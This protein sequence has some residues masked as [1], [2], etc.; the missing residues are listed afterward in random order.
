MDDR[1]NA[2]ET[3]MIS[4][5]IKSWCQTNENIVFD[6]SFSSLLSKTLFSTQVLDSIFGVNKNCG[7]WKCGRF[8]MY[9]IE[10]NE[11][12]IDVY[13]VAQCRGLNKEQVPLYNVLVNSFN[14]V[15]ELE[16]YLKLKC[17]FN[18]ERNSGFDDIKKILSLGFENKLLP[19]EMNLVSKTD[20]IKK[21]LHEGAEKEIL[22]NTYER[23]PEARKKCLE[24]HGYYCHI[25]GFDP[26]KI[27]GEEFKNKI[28]V[29]H[30]VPLSQIKSD[31]VVDPINDLI[32]VCPNCHTIL[33]SKP[34]GVYTP[35]EVK[36]FLKK[37]SE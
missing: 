11:K 28:E 1:K 16:D 21:E 2:F 6:N 25:C 30:I 27:Y 37:T 29:H 19:F 3:N 34:G 26:V 23:N 12:T 24:Y 20:T 32:P 14:D 4:N 8:L 18:I 10:I 13:L 5:Q 36:N 35:E 17:L 15:I 22:S 7:C 33:H 9:Q 31:Y